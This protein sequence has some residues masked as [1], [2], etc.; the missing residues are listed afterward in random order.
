[1]VSIISTRRD[2][3]ALAHQLRVRPN[4]HEPDEQE[5]TAECVGN[6]FDNAGSWPE[7]TSGGTCEMHVYVRQNGTDVAVVNLATLFS[8]ACG[9]EGD[10]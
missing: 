6:T 3:Q 2:L 5:V 7:R 10:Y 4:W 9:Y 1:M 8:W